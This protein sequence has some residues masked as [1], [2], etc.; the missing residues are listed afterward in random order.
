MGEGVWDGPCEQ[1]IL[2]A[3]IEKSHGEACYCVFLICSDGYSKMQSLWLVGEERLE[4]A[5]GDQVQMRS[6]TFEAGT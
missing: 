3:C 1:T 5:R 4:E 6:V 2:C